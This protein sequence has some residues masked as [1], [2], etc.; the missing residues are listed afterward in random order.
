[1]SS[2]FDIWF[3]NMSWFDVASVKSRDKRADQLNRVP[4]RWLEVI[5]KER[6][7]VERACALAAED[8]ESVRIRSI[9]QSSGH[10][11]GERTLYFPKLFIPEFPER[12]FWW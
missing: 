3:H 6:E 2:C 11:G 8:E 5:Q 12:L 1:M 4:Q 7:P 10:L 9:H